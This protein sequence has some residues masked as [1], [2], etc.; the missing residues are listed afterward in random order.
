MCPRPALR[1]RT[2]GIAIGAHGA[3]AALERSSGVELIDRRDVVDGPAALQSLLAD[4][5]LIAVARRR[6]VRIALLPPLVDDRLVTFAGLSV[7]QA[8][9]ALTFR[10]A[11]HFPIPV[12]DPVISGAP[13]DSG[14]EAVLGSMASGVEIGRI[15]SILASADVRC[16]GVHSACAVWLE[17]RGGA[18]PRALVHEGVLTVAIRSGERLTALRRVPLWSTAIPDVLLEAGLPAHA[19]DGTQMLDAAEF[20]ARQM[21][22]CG[23]RE[24][25]TDT[26]RQSRRRRARH[27]T[28]ALLTVAATVAVAGQ[29]TGYVHQ[30]REL[31][32]L[33]R[34]RQQHSEA[35]AAEL[36][37]RN[38]R[39]AVAAAIADVTE[40]ERSAS[41]ADILAQLL[42]LIP[43]GTTLDML[44]IDDDQL[45]LAGGASAA[46]RV[47]A[48]LVAAPVTSRVQ[49]I[50]PV[51]RSAEGEGVAEMFG[52][53]AQLTSDRNIP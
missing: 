4:T 18:A 5:E 41:L 2:V 25:R 11:R 14:R 20:A 27:R 39:E 15:H 28:V 49:W 38:R 21:I 34:L 47:F 3:V 50:G 17:D 36:T 53:T 23:A 8:E 52:L 6:G 13:V 44:E 22:S 32:E 35:A 51:R 30:G 24:L 45:V 48:Q 12:E 7:E 19:L 9:R 42:P 33:R 46:D 40:A 37:L 43:Q 31:A 29:L 26:I 10:A 1:R 16:L